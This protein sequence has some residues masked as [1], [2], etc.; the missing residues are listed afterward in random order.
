MDGQVLGYSAETEEGAIK[1]ESGDRFT[2]KKSD[3]R[4]ERD[5]KAGDKVDFVGADGVATEI[6]LVKGSFSGPDLSGIGDKLGD[7][8]DRKSVV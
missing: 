4:G 3:W 2:F 8:E 1:A 5:P 7:S 6:Y